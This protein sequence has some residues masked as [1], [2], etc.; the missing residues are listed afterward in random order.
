MYKR[1]LICMAACLSL[2]LCQAQTELP[3]VADPLSSLGA[4]LGGTKNVVKKVYLISDTEK[5]VTLSVEF[6]GFKDKKYKIKGFIL[7]SYKKA[8]PEIVP[9]VIDMPASGNTVE[10]TFRFQQKEKAYTQQYLE[11]ALVGLMIVDASSALATV[12]ESFS[13]LNVGGTS[14]QYTFKKK[15]RIS[16]SESMVVQVKMTPVG[17][18]AGIRQ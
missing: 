10:L 2:A 17:Q 5:S 14:L 4:V 12:S 3:L 15:W 18:A 13:D 11:T 9:V 7:N 6:D 8:L 1:I 16:G